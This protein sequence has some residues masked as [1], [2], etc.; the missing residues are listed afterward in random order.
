MQ[1]GFVDSGVCV[2]AVSSKSDQSCLSND[3]FTDFWC[4]TRKCGHSSCEENGD[5]LVWVSAC[6]RNAVCLH[7]CFSYCRPGSPGLLK[8]SRLWR[9]PAGGKSF[10]GSYNIA[11]FKTIGTSFC[12]AIYLFCDST[13]SVNNL[14]AVTSLSCRVCHDPHPPVDPLF[15]DLIKDLVDLA[16]LSMTN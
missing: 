15:K 12:F 6:V 7:L 13:T 16:N 11:L 2:H 3:Q 5:L 10:N 1:S 9:R 4:R 8:A 14:L